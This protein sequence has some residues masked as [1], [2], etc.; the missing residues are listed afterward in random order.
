MNLIY[1][2]NK[3][4]KSSKTLKRTLQY[5]YIVRPTMRNKHFVIN[6]GCSKL[7]NNMHKGYIL[8]HPRAVANAINKLRTFQI[9]QE[10]DVPVPDYTT[11]K[12]KANEWLSL[13]HKVVCRLNL[14]S[15]GGDDIVVVRS[16]ESLPDAPLYTKYHKKKHEFRVHVFK[17]KVIAYSEKKMKRESPP[18]NNLIRNHDNGWVFCITNILHRDDVKQSAINAVAALGLD[19]GGVDVILSDDKPIVLEINTAPGIDAPTTMTAY[20]DAF[21]QER[22]NYVMSF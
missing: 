6:W 17:D 18:T 21:K 8:N 13:G 10:R 19:F 12:Q 4:S 5:K 11:D 1:T 15:H 3:H 20:I 14:S 7:L 22:D 2:Y 16:N 9:L